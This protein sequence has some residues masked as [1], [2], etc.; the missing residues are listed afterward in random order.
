MII[1]KERTLFHEI[2]SI[3]FY[4]LPAV[5]SKKLNFIKLRHLVKKFLLMHLTSFEWKN[6]YNGK[7]DYYIWYLPFPL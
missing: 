2:A 3:P 6:L 1:N 7:I 5:Y 4:I